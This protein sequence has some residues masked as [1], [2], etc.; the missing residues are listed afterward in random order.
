MSEEEISKIDAVLQCDEVT[1]LLQQS[2]PFIDSPEM[3]PAFIPE[4]R[5]DHVLEDS[6]SRLLG[7]SSLDEKHDY[8]E[9][10]S[11]S[12]DFDIDLATVRDANRV[13]NVSMFSFAGYIQC[14]YSS[15]SPKQLVRSGD[16]DQ[17]RVRLSY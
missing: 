6:I 14:F 3:P 15:C 16:E 12:H 1:Q 5:D 8:T 2:D 4:D 7:E 10:A 13:L 11:T 17:T 9:I